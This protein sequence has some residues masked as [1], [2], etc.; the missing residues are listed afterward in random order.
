MN[1][2]GAL[3]GGMLIAVAVLFSGRYQLVATESGIFRLD[4]VTGSVQMCL[5]KKD[6]PFHLACAGEIDD[7]VAV[8]KK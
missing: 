4:R 3:I 1:G 5:P 6:H 2:R 8:P 7:W